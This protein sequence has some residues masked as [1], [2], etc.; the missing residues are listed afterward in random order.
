MRPSAHYSCQQWSYSALR[1]VPEART[2]FSVF[3]DEAYAVFSLLSAAAKRLFKE[4]M[5]RTTTPNSPSHFA[6]GTSS[7]QMQAAKL[8]RFPFACSLHTVY[9]TH[10]VVNL[11][12]RTH[13]TRPAPEYFS[14]SH[15][16]SSKRRVSTI[17]DSAPG[18][19]LVNTRC[20][21]TNVRGSRNPHSARHNTSKPLSGAGNPTRLFSLGC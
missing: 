8:S 11:S 9:D 21:S 1:Q 6:A 19:L 7:L 5:A 3:R 13:P 20:S 4:R 2:L 10:S 14:A 16:S 17:L 12:A 18:H 15:G